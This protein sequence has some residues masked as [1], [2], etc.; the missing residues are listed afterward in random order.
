[1]EI[2]LLDNS[3]TI[4]LTVIG[5]VFFAALA[6][7]NSENKFLSSI[8]V[9]APSLLTSLGI[10]FT[11]LGIFI[12]LQSFNTETDKIDESIPP[13]LSGLKLAFFSSV[14]GL[15]G[16]I[17]FRGLKPLIEKEISSEEVSAADLHKELIKLNEG[18]LAVKD[19]IIGEGDA[20]LSTQIMKLRTDFRDFAE[21]VKEDG[22]EAL[23]KALEEV[24]KDFNTKINEQFGENFKQLNQAVAAL[25]EWQQEYKE[26]VLKLTEA[27]QET[28]KGIDLVK[29]SIENIEESTS[30]I[31]DQMTKVDDVFEKTDNR[32][33]ELHKGLSTLSEMRERAESALPKIEEQMINMTQGFHDAINKQISS[34]NENFDAQQ[35]NFNETNSKFT[36]VLDSLNIASDNLLE[37]TGNVSQEIKKTIESFQNEQNAMTQELQTSIKASASEVEQLMNQSIQSLDSSMQEQLQRSLDI[38]GNNLTSIVQR[39][40]DVYEPFATRVQGI[41]TRLDQNDR[42]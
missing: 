35:N 18:T 41:M 4:A 14:L 15:A 1:M 8:A 34:F 19:A 33:E 23:I 5:I 21:K 36:G 38:L 11:F 27:F 12:A 16:A 42:T 40:V 37:S 30:K 2:L 28:Q 22:S 29:T 9:N 7:L 17:V 25:L 31:P 3:Q 10:F 6:G 24:I 26:Q 20:S 39:F 32:M 13:L